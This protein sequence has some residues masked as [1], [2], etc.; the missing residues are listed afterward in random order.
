MNIFKVAKYLD[1]K[2]ADELT[3]AETPQAIRPPNVS[4]PVVEDEPVR[5]MKDIGSIYYNIPTEEEIKFL[6]LL[7]NEMRSSEDN[8]R[9]I[10][11]NKFMLD[12]NM[13]IAQAM[14]MAQ[15]VI[16]YRSEM[17]AGILNKL[18]YFKDNPPPVFD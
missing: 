11:I 15:K 18:V 3:G 8:L 10:F 4:E 5:K 9:K 7:A 17:I 13:D 12:K 2:I 16:A 6:R 1:K 14:E